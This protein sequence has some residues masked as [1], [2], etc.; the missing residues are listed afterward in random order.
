MKLYE[1]PEFLV[2]LFAVEDI[3]AASAET[4]DALKK[5]TVEGGSDSWKAE[6]NGIYE[7]N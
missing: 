5:A 7:V 4:P 2:K 6:W 3:I 1:K